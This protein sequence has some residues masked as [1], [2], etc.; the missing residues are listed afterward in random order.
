[1]TGSDP[2]LA[3]IFVIIIHY[4]LPVPNDIISC[5]IQHTSDVTQE[6]PALISILQ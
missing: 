4:F 6:V 3:L 2:A 5:H 1:M